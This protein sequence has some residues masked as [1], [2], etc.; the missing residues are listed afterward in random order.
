MEFAPIGRRAVVG[1]MRAQMGPSLA[2]RLLRREDPITGIGI[3]YYQSQEEPRP[4]S[5]V[6]PH[7]DDRADWSVVTLTRESGVQVEAVTGR[8]NPAAA[9][10][11]PVIFHYDGRGTV[12]ELIR[13]GGRWRPV[14]WPAP[15]G[16]DQW[17]GGVVA[18]LEPPVAVV[19]IAA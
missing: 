10:P 14:D 7:G 3:R 2:S 15:D 19:D 18:D 9:E 12:T 8:Y 16:P 17:A 5:G 13:E 6:G 1:W 11:T 4:G